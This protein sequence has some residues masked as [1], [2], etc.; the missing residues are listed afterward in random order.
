MNIVIING[1]N[2]NLLGTREPDKYGS[3][4]FIEVYNNLKINYPQVNFTY[5]QT[6]IEGE[7]VN[8]IQQYGTTHNIIIN[9]AAYTHTSVAIGDA[10]LATKAK[11]IEVHISNVMA[12][13]DF[14]KISFVSAVCIGTITGLGM[15]GYQSAVQY[16]IAN[17]N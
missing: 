9:P 11:A 17:N 5:F 15:Y 13:E 12:R 3:Q 4:T 8:A 10:I 7:I 2:L 6:N 1:P 14:R 16:F